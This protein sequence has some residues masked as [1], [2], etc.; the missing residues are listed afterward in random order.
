VAIS[1][2][3]DHRAPTRIEVQAMTRTLPLILLLFTATGPRPAAAESAEKKTPTVEALSIK[4][5]MV[6]DRIARLE[7]HM[8]RLREKL[9]E[10]E[11]ENARRLGAALEQVGA[12]DVSTRMAR[13]AEALESTGQ[14][15][16][17]LGEQDKLLTDL[18]TVLAV[19]LDR[20]PNDAR[21]REELRRLAAIKQDLDR[22]LQ[23]QNEARRQTARQVL[24]K[25]LARKVAEAKQQLQRLESEQQD[26]ARR[27]RESAPGDQGQSQ[28]Q[29]R[30][31]A[32]L[33]QRAERLQRELERLARRHAQLRAMS[34]AIRSE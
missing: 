8:F 34:R 28:A 6:R 21:R 32:Q 11:P 24:T 7:D 25:R 2:R 29:A 3:I 17:S 15:D 10:T 26:L 31:Q 9:A 22:L 14:L 33:A 12:L 30:E 27:S 19:L 18:E 13:L 1:L 20:D 4:Q 23:E 16:Q 5:Q